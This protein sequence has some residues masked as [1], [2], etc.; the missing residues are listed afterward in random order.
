MLEMGPLV[1]GV[2]DKMN[3]FKKETE[4]KCAMITGAARGFGRAIASAFH[5]GGWTVLRIVRTPADVE[6]LSAAFTE[7]CSPILADV[8]DFTACDRVAETIAE[9]RGHLSVLVNNAGIG[10]YGSTIDAID[11]DSINSLVATHCL[12]ALRFAKLCAPFLRDHDDGW[13]VN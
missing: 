7:R 13:I 1:P 2:N 10:G 11:L 6:T 9:T 4:V 12:G 3:D 5:S 8:R